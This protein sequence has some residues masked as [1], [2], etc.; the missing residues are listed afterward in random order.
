MLPTS[1]GRTMLLLVAAAIPGCARVY[2][3]PEPGEPAALLKVKLAYDHAAALAT[4]PPDA[5]NRNLVAEIFVEVEGKRYS[6]ATKTFVDALASAEP[7][8]LETLAVQLHPER[9]AVFSVRL[10]AVWTTTRP[11][12]VWKEERKSRTVPK[13]VYSYNSF[14]KRTEAQTQM[15][16]EYYTER[17]QVTELVTRSSS[18]GCAATLRLR[19]AKD[20]VYLVDYANPMLTEACTATGYLQKVRADGSFEL[21]AIE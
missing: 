16:T 17:R 11:E 5:A 12:Q 4:L 13:T 3:A 15:Q 2:K 14:S 8:P 10:S 1:L 7:L 9:D 20:G 18:A 19:P 6:V 21:G